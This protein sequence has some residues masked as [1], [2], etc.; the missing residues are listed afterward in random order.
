MSW[1]TLLHGQMC[2]RLPYSVQA[3]WRHLTQVNIAT[4]WALEVSQES[5]F[6]RK[7]ERS[8]VQLAVSINRMTI[9]NPVKSRAKPNRATLL[10][11]F[12]A[13]PVKCRG[14]SP[15]IHE[16][17]AELPRQIATSCTLV[18]LQVESVKL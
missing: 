1:Y 4:S 16:V 15:R 12:I 2:Y 3:K 14:K 6:F 18:H 7:V 13:Y 10:D 8:W 5:V 9:G 17:L 11:L